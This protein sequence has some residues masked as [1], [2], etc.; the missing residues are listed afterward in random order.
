MLRSS[1]LDTSL[2]EGSVIEKIEAQYEKTSATLV[3]G[4]NTM[5]D[6]KEEIK[7][8]LDELADKAE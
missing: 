4:L 8:D 2:T 1:S 5:M 6:F 7:R 3:N